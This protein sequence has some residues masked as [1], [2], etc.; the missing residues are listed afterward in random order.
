MSETELPRRRFLACRAYAHALDLDWEV[1]RRELT[2]RLLD[3]YRVPRQEREGGLEVWRYRSQPA[4]LDLAAQVAR[5]G[6]LAVIVHVRVRW[7]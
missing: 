5:E 1:A 3:A 2:E 7:A 6:R 4:G